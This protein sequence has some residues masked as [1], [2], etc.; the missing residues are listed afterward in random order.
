[1][2]TPATKDDIQPLVDTLKKIQEKWPASS[3]NGISSTLEEAVRNFRA[4]HWAGG[5]LRLAKIR[6]M[7]AVKQDPDQIVEKFHLDAWKLAAKCGAAAELRSQFEAPAPPSTAQ[8]SY[9]KA[10]VSGA[11]RKEKEPE[12]DALQQLVASKLVNGLTPSHTRELIVL[13]IEDPRVVDI[14]YKLMCDSRMLQPG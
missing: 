12:S 6:R 11:R 2:A 7:E 5:F 14:L 8:A 13:M 1:M 9:A 4:G 3:G 10:S